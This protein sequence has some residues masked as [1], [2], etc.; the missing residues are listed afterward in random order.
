MTRNSLVYSYHPVPEQLSASSRK[1]KLTDT[2]DVAVEKYWNR[3]IRELMQPVGHPSSKRFF[4]KQVKAAHLL[5]GLAE[6]A[7]D[8]S[9]ANADE[10]A[11][12]AALKRVAHRRGFSP[13]QLLISSVKRTAAAA[14]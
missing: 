10:W 9:I 14:E 11:M 12:I 6:T 7:G 2:V 3:E 5:K 13:R 1:V 4:L 8:T